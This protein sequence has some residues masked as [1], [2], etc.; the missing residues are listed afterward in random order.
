MSDEEVVAPR[1]KASRAKKPVTY[2]FESDS[3]E[4]F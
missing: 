1:S 2:N 3:D 4:G